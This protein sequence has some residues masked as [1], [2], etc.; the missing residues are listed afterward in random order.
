MRF[1]NQTEHNR[2]QQ[3]ELSYTRHNCTSAICIYNWN[4]CLLVINNSLA[5]PSMCLTLPHQ[6][7]VDSSATAS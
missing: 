5:F 7:V 6:T 2:K 3:Y 4:A 1:S